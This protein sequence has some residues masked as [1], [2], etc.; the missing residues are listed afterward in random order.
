MA[1]Y[2]LTMTLNGG[3]GDKRA[4]VASA[5][6]APPI[7]NQIQLVIKDTVDFT[8]RLEILN[9]WRYLMNGLRERQ[10]DAG[11]IGNDVY[12]SM[13]IDAVGSPARKTSTSA[14]IMVDGD[15]AIVIDASL[16]QKTGS[17]LALSNAFT[18]LRESAKEISR[19]VA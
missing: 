6:I 7:A 2:Q 17:P 19:W 12:S 15:V 10:F 4:V 11:F 14:A 3:A 13:P 16:V 9:A 8:R 1:D 18:Q 5:T